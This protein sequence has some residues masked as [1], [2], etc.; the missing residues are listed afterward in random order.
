MK[1]YSYINMIVSE[2][3]TYED[4]QSEDHTCKYRLL[5]PQEHNFNICLT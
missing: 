2:F 3:V 1:N 4:I 5:K